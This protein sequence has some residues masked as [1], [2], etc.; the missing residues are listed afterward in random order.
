MER[1]P[2]RK[3]SA[4]TRLIFTAILVFWGLVLVG[5]ALWLSGHESPGGTAACL[6]FSA[7]Y[8][9]F[10]WS[11]YHSPN[12]SYERGANGGYASPPSNPRSRPS[13]HGPNQRSNALETAPRPRKWPPQ[14]RDLQA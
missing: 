10:A 14:S 11:L 9:W 6:I 2:A 1:T 4:A 13:I 7:G 8:F 12:V 3:E 5:V